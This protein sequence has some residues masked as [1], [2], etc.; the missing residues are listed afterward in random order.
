M[1]NWWINAQ[2][3]NML[4]GVPGD[5]SNPPALPDSWIVDFLWTNPRARI[6][7][8][9]II[10]SMLPEEQ[11]RLNNLIDANPYLKTGYRNDP[12]VQSDYEQ[13]KWNRAGV[14]TAGSKGGVNYGQG[15]G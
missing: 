11:E 7:Y 2:G 12:T 4:S 8:N 6:G 13:N 3:K 10:G 14:R 1:S 9:A 15:I 5:D